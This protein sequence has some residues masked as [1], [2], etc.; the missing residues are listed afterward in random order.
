MTVPAANTCARATALA[1]IGDLIGVPGV[2]LRKQLPR[3]W[4][5]VRMIGIIKL[6]QEDCCER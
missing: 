5:R 2:A 3:T 1:H 6:N 4:A